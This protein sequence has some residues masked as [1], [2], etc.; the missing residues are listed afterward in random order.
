MAATIKDIANMT[1]LGLATIS[2]YLNGGSVRPKNK[3]KI[4]KAISELHYEVNETA[5]QLKTNRTR[6]IGAVIPELSNSFCGKVL[7]H[8]ED[9]VRQ[10]GYAVLVCDCRSDKTREKEA[11]D[12]LMR[13]RVDGLFIIPVDPT[14]DNLRDFRKTGKP[15]VVMDRE[16]RALNCDSV[17]VDNRKAIHQAVRLLTQKGHKHIGMLACPEEN[18]TAMERIRGYREA[19]E[20]FG[21]ESNED[22]IYKGN[23]TIDS[24]A[25]G[26]E[27]LLGK[28]PELTAVIAASYRMGMGAVIGIN[29]LGIEV[30]EQLSLVGFDDPQF[31]RAV[32][33]QLT[34]IN[35]PVSRI[36]E[37]AAGLMLRRLQETEC[38]ETEHICLDT[39]ILE[40][41]SV[42]SLC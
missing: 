41:R 2:S 28:F 10:H 26:I 4:E 37:E 13:R 18:H 1:G 34:I 11:V 25:K 9:V 30:P 24:G 35:Q 22:Y 23:D 42:A 39:S 17:V 20:E 6:S 5:R 27:E 19:V 14:G 21:L 7:S 40:G 31:A 38:S 12:F 36:G 29:E 32:H 3:E 15:I 8:I 33:P 16:I